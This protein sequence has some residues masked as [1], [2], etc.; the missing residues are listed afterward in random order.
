MLGCEPSF[1]NVL[2]LEILQASLPVVDNNRN[3]VMALSDVGEVPENFTR[4]VLLCIEAN[5]CNQIFVGNVSPRYT[6]YAL[7]H[8]SQITIFLQ[9]VC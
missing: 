7:L 2:C 3:V 4:L 5:D 6:R 9:K 8:R 1:E